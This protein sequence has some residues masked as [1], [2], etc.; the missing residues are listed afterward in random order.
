MKKI[1]I[2]ITLILF[3]SIAMLKETVAIQLNSLNDYKILTELDIELDHYRT[4]KLVHAYATDNEIKLLNN[5][6][7]IVNKIPNQPY[8]YYQGLKA[9]STRNPLEEYHNYN[10]LTAFLNEIANQ[11]PEITFLE[12]IGQSVQGREL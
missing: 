4:K 10:E 5:I 12:S 1:K 2:Y 11:Y 3:F 7:F 6:G 8:E 9:E